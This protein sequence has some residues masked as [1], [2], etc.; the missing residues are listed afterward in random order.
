MCSLS[1]TDQFRH[2]TQAYED[3]LSIL[4]Q[5]LLYRKAGLGRFLLRFLP[6]R[7][8]LHQIDNT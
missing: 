2:K 6:R 4:A 3:M 7:V 8:I 5:K 1:L